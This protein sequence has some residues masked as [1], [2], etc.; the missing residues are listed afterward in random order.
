MKRATL[1]ETLN[2]VVPKN[3]DDIIRI[4]RDDLTLRMSTDEDLAGLPPMASTLNHQMQIRATINEWRVVCL[5]LHKAGKKHILTG[6][7]DDTNTVWGTSELLSA[8]LV[9][10]LVLTKNSIYRLGFK[11]SG[12]PT[13][14]LLLHICYLFHQWG[15]GPKFGVPKIIY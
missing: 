6:Y 14:D 5:D 12:E 8:D 9:Q 4:R 3:L 7:Y 10:N 11:G 1:E 13:S 15:F 2:Q